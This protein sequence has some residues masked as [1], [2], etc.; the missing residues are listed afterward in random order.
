MMGST[1]KLLGLASVNI[2]VALALSASYLTH[3]GGK[4]QALTDE[5]AS[6][7]V[8]EFSGVKTGQRA[9]MDD[10]A[11]VA[12]LMKHIAERGTLTTSINSKIPGVAARTDVMRKK[13]F[14][15]N[16]LQ[17]M[18]E[19]GPHPASVKVEDIKIAGDGH[20]A[21]VVATI[22]ETLAMEVKNPE[23]GKAGVSPVSAMS[24]CSESLQISNEHIIQIRS[25]TCTTEVKPI[26]SF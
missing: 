14:I 16:A 6:G 3:Y 9:D 10:H 21:T 13:D 17:L 26:D 5:T 4:A 1:I 15:A 23:N 11:V 22:N 19:K 2:F 20:T 8:R 12:Y 25:E 24:Y 7:F 18:R